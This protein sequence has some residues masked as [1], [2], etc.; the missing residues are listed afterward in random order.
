M[1]KVRNT[2]IRRPLY[3]GFTYKAAIEDAVSNLDID[4]KGERVRT[5]KRFTFLDKDNTLLSDP[6]YETKF[7]LEAYYS[8]RM[9]KL[10]LNRAEVDYYNEL[11]EK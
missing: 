9:I 7:Y 4:L 11:K 6:V 1:S 5:T 3:Q 10:P 8:G 2:I